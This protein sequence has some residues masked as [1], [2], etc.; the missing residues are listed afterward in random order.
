MLNSRIINHYSIISGWQ[1][2]AVSSV[3]LG[4]CV[5]SPCQRGFPLGA[6]VSSNSLKCHTI[7]W[8]LDWPHGIWLTVWLCEWVSC[9]VLE[10]G[11][12]RHAV[13]K[14]YERIKNL[15]PYPFIINTT[16]PVTIKKTSKV[17]PSFGWEVR[18][19]LK[20]SPIYQRVKTEMNNQFNSHSLW[21][22]YI[23]QLA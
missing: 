23:T 1:G 14:T 9:G 10:L 18:Y 17:S 21:A 19:R 16:Y 4:A 5:L 15:L 2:G 13:Q 22:I 6:P 11:P 20:R 7:G 3:V 8:W 12:G